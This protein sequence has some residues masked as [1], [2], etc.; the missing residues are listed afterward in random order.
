MTQGVREQLGAP[1]KTTCPDTL[2][3]ELARSAT[4]LHYVHCVD[5][6]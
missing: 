1:G 5:L 4:D 6:P 2:A 3:Q